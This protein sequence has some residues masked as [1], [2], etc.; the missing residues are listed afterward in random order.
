VSQ[1]GFDFTT[2]V[3]AELRYKNFMPVGSPSIP[4][5]LRMQSWDFCFAQ[6]LPP[7][8][9]YQNYP[10]GAGSAYQHNMKVDVMFLTGLIS[11]KNIAGEE[12]EIG[13][14]TTYTAFD[15]N[16]DTRAQE[17]YDFN[18]DGASDTVLLGTIKTITNAD[19][20]EV[21]AFVLESEFTDPEE[22]PEL[23]GIYFDGAQDD[24]EER[25]EVGSGLES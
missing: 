15:E 25:K 8:A 12:V 18:G 17:F 2:D 1:Q 4:Y 11:L 13:E 6:L 10:P 19:G 20:V 14:T 24:P 22:E 16:A 3:W 5:C 23:Q 9:S 21:E 7:F